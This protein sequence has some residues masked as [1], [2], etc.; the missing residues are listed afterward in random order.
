MPPFQDYKMVKNIEDLKHNCPD[1]IDKIGS[2]P[3]QYSISLEPEIPQVQH[4][5]YRVPIKAKEEIKAQLREMMV[6]III[7]LQVGSGMGSLTY[8]YKAN[9]SLGVCLDL[10]D[11]NKVI[12]HDHYKA[13]H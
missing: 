6:Q 8:P 7:T 11:L 13:L 5:I 4:G 2:M 12:S 9:G 3:R 1:S 10:K